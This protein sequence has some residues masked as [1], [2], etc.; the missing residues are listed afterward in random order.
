MQASYMNLAK[1]ALAAALVVAATS[2]SAASPAEPSLDL[3]RAP[4]TEKVLGQIAAGVQAGL[5]AEKKPCENLLEGVTLGSKHKGFS[6]LNCV[7]TAGGVLLWGESHEGV[8]DP[9]LTV[10]KPFVRFVEADRIV[11]VLA[12]GAR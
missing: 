5:L 10:V 7:S 3:V 11:D 9:A 8:K 6:R 2:A 1:Q 12:T 4:L